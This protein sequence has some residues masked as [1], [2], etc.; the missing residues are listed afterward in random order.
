MS[1]K[2]IITD[3]HVGDGG[4]QDDWVQR[5]DGFDLLHALC[6]ELADYRRR[7]DAQLI[8]TG[9]TFNGEC[10]PR[11]CIDGSTYR[12]T[13]NMLREFNPILCIGNHDSEIETFRTHSIFKRF[14][15]THEIQLGHTL[16]MHG[17]QVDLFCGKWGWIGKAVSKAAWLIGKVNPDWE[18]ALRASGGRDG[19]DVKFAKRAVA[20]AHRMGCDR[21][22]CGHSHEPQ[23]VT[24]EYVNGGLFSRDGWLVLDDK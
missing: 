1:R 13:M 22:V 23:I 19:D 7:H 24:P 4:P 15:L 12:E 3:L 14:Y 6:L 20:Y 11:A 10:G 8:I 5:P 16:F 2:F 9:D 18:D 21:I 17:H